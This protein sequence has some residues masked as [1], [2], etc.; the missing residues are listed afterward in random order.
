[1]RF[2]PPDPG[3]SNC[4]GT[5]LDGRAHDCGCTDHEAEC[6]PSWCSPRCRELHDWW[7]G[8]ANNIFGDGTMPAGT[9]PGSRTG[10]SPGRTDVALN[11]A[12]SRTVIASLLCDHCGLPLKA[13]DAV[14]CQLCAEEVARLHD[15]I[16]AA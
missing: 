5:G 1:M 8:C 4:G 16:E 2:F 10:L 9:G 12:Y 7:D 14:V 11:A 6:E 13:G 15:A 3:C